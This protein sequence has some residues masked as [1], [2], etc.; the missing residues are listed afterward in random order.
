M[1][2]DKPI[3]ILI[4]IKRI[5]FFFSNAYIAYR[6]MLTVLMLVVSAERSFSKLKIIKAYLR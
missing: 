6:I 2:N 4:H 3:D 5:V 1:E